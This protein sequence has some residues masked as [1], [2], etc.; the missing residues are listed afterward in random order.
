VDG[1]VWSDGDLGSAQG[2]F[3][4]LLVQ[5]SSQQ[6]MFPGDVLG[7]GT[8]PGGCAV[9]LG[10]RL[11]PGAIVELETAG[12]G[13]LRNRVGFPQENLQPAAMQR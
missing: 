11:R 4:Q 12:I 8:F 2:T 3:P 1:E 7:S 9:D 13:G 5:F 10:L 6:D